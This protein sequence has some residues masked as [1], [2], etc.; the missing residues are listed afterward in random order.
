MTIDSPGFPSYGAIAG[1]NSSGEYPM[2]LRDWSE[3]ILESS[4]SQQILSIAFAA[5]RGL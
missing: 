5:L 1:S 3:M 4:Y 2:F